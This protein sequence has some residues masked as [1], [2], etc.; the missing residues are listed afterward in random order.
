MSILL[1]FEIPTGRRVEI[2]DEG[3]A[4]FFG[5]TQLSGKTTLIEAITFRAPA[6]VKAVAFITKRGEGSF[7]TARMISPYFSEP[8][9]DP[10]QPLWRWVSAILEA[11]Q[12]RKLRF[13]ESWIIRACEEPKRAKSLADVHSNIISL[14]EG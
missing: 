3:H 11:S 13:E 4:A 7:L 12:Q 14:V 9:N 5:Q 1:G 8:T 2:P 10:E 6:N